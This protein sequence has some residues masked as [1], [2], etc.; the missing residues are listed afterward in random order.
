MRCL[1]WATPSPDII[2]WVEAMRYPT[3]C[4][5]CW[6]TLRDLATFLKRQLLPCGNAKSEQVGTAQRTGSPT[7]TKVIL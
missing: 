7:Y 3:F 5:V 6:V 2:C 1:L 4:M